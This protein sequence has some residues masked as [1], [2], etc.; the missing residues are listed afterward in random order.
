M[1]IAWIQITDHYDDHVLSRANISV[2][3]RE[4]PDAPEPSAPA[5]LIGLRE[6]LGDPATML[7]KQV[8]MSLRDV[9]LT[10]LRELDVAL[11]IGV[12]R[13]DARLPPDPASF[14]RL[15]DSS[16]AGYESHCG[17]H[18]GCVVPRG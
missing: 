16:N 11:Q 13:G 14:M 4:Q 17:R 9:A 2:P 12:V 8:R 10:L 6:G 7:W 5:H 3:S 15:S 1:A 18:Q